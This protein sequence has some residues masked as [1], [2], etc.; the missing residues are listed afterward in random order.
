MPAQCAGRTPRIMP[1]NRKEG[2]DLHT[3]ARYL[4]NLIWSREEGEG[5]REKCVD[6]VDG[7]SLN[8]GRT[9]NAHEWTTN[10]F[11]S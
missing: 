6:G 9:T 8:G 5:R 11:F 1:K 10:S 7:A 4:H 2:G 3:Y